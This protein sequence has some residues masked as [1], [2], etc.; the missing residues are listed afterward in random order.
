[1]CHKV[2]NACLPPHLFPELQPHIFNS[3]LHISACLSNIHI[4]EDMFKTKLSILY[5]AKPFFLQTLITQR[6]VPLSMQ[7][8]KPKL[9]II[10]FFSSFCPACKSISKFLD[11]SQNHP[12]PSMSNIF[13]LAKDIITSCLDYCVASQMDSPFPH[14]PTEVLH[15]AA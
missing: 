4:K 6:I 2:M 13:T 8:L 3:P 15:T 7:Y 5:P 1:M 9:E 11:S 14:L 12:C 10:P